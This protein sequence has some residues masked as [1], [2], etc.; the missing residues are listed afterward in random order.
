MDT[1]LILYIESIPKY[2]WNSIKD[3]PEEF[4]EDLCRVIDKNS[5]TSISLYWNTF[6]PEIFMVTKR[7]KI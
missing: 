4:R 5:M 7:T 1:K 3:V 6:Y 2:Q